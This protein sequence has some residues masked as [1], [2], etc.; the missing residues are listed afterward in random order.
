MKR[1]GVRFMVHAH[2]EKEDIDAMLQHLANIY[3]EVL[4]AENSSLK[5]VARTFG[6]PEFSPKTTAKV[7]ARQAA[8]NELTIEIKH[9]IKDIDQ[10][11]WDAIFAGQGQ[12]HGREP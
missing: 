8:E 10:E 4:T 1:G 2:L 12:F 9:S 11:A 5:K 6:I 3:E 7:N